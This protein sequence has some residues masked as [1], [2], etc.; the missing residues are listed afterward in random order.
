MEIIQDVNES[1]LYIYNSIFVKTG[2]VHVDTVLQK[3][4]Q[5][6][7]NLNQIDQNGNTHIIRD[8]VVAIRL[9]VS[10]DKSNLTLPDIVYALYELV[11]LCGK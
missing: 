11:Y 9:L 10:T 6:L 8:Y 1:I 4:D 7:C 5:I 3:C 2:D